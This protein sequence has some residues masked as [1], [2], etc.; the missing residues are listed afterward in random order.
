MQILSFVSEADRIADTTEDLIY[1]G[2]PRDGIIEFNLTG[3]VTDYYGRDD[4]FIPAHP[5]KF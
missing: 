1:P 3:Y 4:E 5:E 2:Q